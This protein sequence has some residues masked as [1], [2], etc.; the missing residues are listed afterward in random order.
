MKIKITFL[1]AAQN[2]TGSRFVVE[3]VGK[4]FLVDCGIFQERP[5]RERN[6]KPFPI[7]PSEIDFA[8]LTHAHLDHCGYLPRLVKDGF[9]GPVYCTGPSA[10][11][12]KIVMIDSGH[13][14]EEDARKKLKRHRRENRRGPFAVEPL[15]TMDDAEKASELLQSVDYDAE[16]EIAPGIRATFRDAGHIL[17]SSVV[18]LKIT[19]GEESRTILFSG[20]LGRPDKPIL[21]DPTFL[22]E[23]DYVVMESTY[24][25][26]DHAATADIATSIAEE[27]NRAYKAHGNVIIPT[28]A[29]ERAHELLY[30]L[31]ELLREKRIPTVKVFL[32][33]PMAIRVTEVFKRHAEIYD[34]E[35]RQYVRDGKSPFDFPGL[36]MSVTVDQSKA[37]NDAKGTSIIMAGSGMCTGGRIKHHLVQNIS[38]ERNTLLFVGYQAVG[39]LGRILVEGREEVR[40]FNKMYPVR[41]RVAQVRG[42]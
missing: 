9:H 31:N 11:V 19:E 17:G 35:M 10:E 15:Y 38:D 37:I 18:K 39:T 28:F 20:D 23:A 8:I 22:A 40:I 26:R 32:D 29:V 5:L 4:T 41:A 16:R 25:D 27:I 13:I 3:A 42:F 21:K 34:E 30:Y 36:T 7:S 12:A 1:G 14:Q 24:G 33:S 2:V 6:W